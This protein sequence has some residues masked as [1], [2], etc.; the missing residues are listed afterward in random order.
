MGRVAA[1]GGGVKISSDI[2][3]IYMVGFEFLII[4]FQFKMPYM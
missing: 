4:L 1:A 2:K 3:Y